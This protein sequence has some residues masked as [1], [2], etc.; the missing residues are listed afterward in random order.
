MATVSQLRIYTIKDGM[1]DQW[2]KGWS[3]GVYPLRLKLGFTIKAW[4]I[5]EENKF[6]WV[7]SYD[8]PNTW[9]AQEAAYQA[10]PD[11]GTLHPEL[12]QYLVDTKA[13]FIAPV[14]LE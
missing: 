5:E 3:E 7:V 9:E 4:S 6:V 1:M 14:H 10:S 8:G 12:G 13:W 2:I 11:L